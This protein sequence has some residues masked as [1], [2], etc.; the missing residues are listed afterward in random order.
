MKLH[1]IAVGTR[2]PKW[3]D[4][5]WNDYAKRMP[6]D[7][8]LLLHEIKPA[9]RTSGKS[10]EQLLLLE[11][12]RIQISLPAQ[13]WQVVLDERGRELSTAALAT[14]L[15]FWQENQQTVALVVGGPDGLHHQIK[16]QANE[17]LRLSA[18]TLPH[19]LVRIL[20]AEQLYRAWSILAGHPYH[21]A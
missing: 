2:M 12:Q 11:A 21:R 16:Q 14:R 5:A 20:L 13:A 10:T 4:E 19:P 7:F 9:A 6:S 18:L 3:V 17:T 15:R 1:I 8:E